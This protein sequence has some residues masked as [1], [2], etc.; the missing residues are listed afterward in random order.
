MNHTVQKWLFRWNFQYLALN[1]GESV[2]GDDKIFHFT[3]N[4]QDIRLV[5]AKPR[6]IELW[7]YE[8]CSTL[9][10]DCKYMIFLKLHLGGEF[11]SIS[12]VGKTWTRVIRTLE[13]EQI[14]LTIDC[15][16][17][18]NVS[19]EV[20]QRSGI[21]YIA[22]FSSNTFQEV[23]SEMSKNVTVSGEWYGVC[24]PSYLNSIVYH[25]CC[26]DRVENKWV[27]SNTCVKSTSRVIGPIIPLFDLCKVT[28]NVCDRF[29]RSLRNTF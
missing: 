18:D 20:W 22:A 11:T 10:N 23:I 19:K 13:H 9:R 15:Y 25:R 21:K 16:Y 12:S 4:S 3:G 2:A 1:L 6:R 7:F 27:M 24:N 17:L 28:F 5:S 8:L 29:N 26:D 14:F